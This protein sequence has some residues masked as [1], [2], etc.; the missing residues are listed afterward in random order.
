MISIHY[1]K[2]KPI[3]SI[4]GKHV[5]DDSIIGGLDIVQFI[6]IN[7]QFMGYN[8]DDQIVKTLRYN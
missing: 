7:V 4:E 3:L 8:V 2:V 6:Y 5:D 1:E